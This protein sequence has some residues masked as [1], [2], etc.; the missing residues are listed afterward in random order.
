MFASRPLR[1]ALRIAA[2]VVLAILLMMT[3]GRVGFAPWATD[4]L[5]RTSAALG[6]YGDEAIE[7]FYMIAT[8]AL[9]V[10]L[11]GAIVLLGERALTARRDVER[12]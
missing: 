8:M 6:I 12:G 2:F 7:N 10:V 5:V 3:F 9:S 11:A 1:L 4:L